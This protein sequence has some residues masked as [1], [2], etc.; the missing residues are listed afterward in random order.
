MTTI[1]FQAIEKIRSENLPESVTPSELDRDSQIS[2]VMLNRQKLDAPAAN[3]LD[4]SIGNGVEDEPDRSAIEE[5]PHTLSN[6][7]N[8]MPEEIR[9]SMHALKSVTKTATSITS[10]S[11]NNVKQKTGSTRNVNTD[12]HI[13]EIRASVDVLFKS[14]KSLHDAAPKQQ[15]HPSSN[16]SSSS[17]KRRRSSQLHP[18]FISA[19]DELR[20]SVMPVE[21]LESLANGGSGGGGTRRRSS[22]FGGSNGNLNHQGSRRKSSIRPSAVVV[23]VVERLRSSHPMYSTTPDLPT[24][25]P[26]S[27]Y[28]QLNPRN[29]SSNASSIAT[30]SHVKKSS[31]LR[32][33]YPDYSA[34]GTSSRR[35]SSIVTESIREGDEES[36]NIHA[37]HA[38]A[39]K[40]QNSNA[41]GWK[42]SIKAV[43]FPTTINE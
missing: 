30:G 27:D 6:R 42:A 16:F 37:D 25:T 17:M 9:I 32:A 21:D 20:D 39:G 11:N 2:D 36:T 10:G 1:L 3:S 31:N 5:Q 38:D 12:H 8:N 28:Q 23:P 41:Q 7:L 13:D 15:P 29:T 4:S 19:V 24:S 14:Q 35:G 34:D 43:V 40:L 26:S 18:I 22:V 33:V